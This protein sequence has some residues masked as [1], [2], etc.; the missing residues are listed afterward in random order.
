M[1][2]FPKEH[3][4]YGQVTVPLITAF[5]AAGVSTTGLLIATAVLTGFLAHEPA[6]V[7]IGIRGVRAKRELRPRA[8]RWLGCTLAV[9]IAPAAGAVLTMHPAQ[10]WSII[11]PAAPAFVTATDVSNPAGLAGR[12]RERMPS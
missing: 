8:V 2:L 11:V 6:L 4:A 5:L 10:R 7:L 9:G 3:G 1:S 12:G